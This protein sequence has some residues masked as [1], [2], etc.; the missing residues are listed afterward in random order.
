MTVAATPVSPRH[1]VPIP[2]HRARPRP[3]LLA[4]AAFLASLALAGCNQAHE[5]GTAGERIERSTDAAKHAIG[6]VVDAASTAVTDSGITVAVKMKLAEDTDLQVMNIDVQT[7]AG[8]TQL[9]GAAPDAAARVRATRIARAV[10]GV[11]SVD[12][13]LTLRD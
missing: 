5:P 6:N 8:R 13:R 1:H 9:T 10:D 4:G 12:N 7:S 2:R 11:T 3:H